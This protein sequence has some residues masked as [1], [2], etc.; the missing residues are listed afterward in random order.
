VEFKKGAFIAHP[1]MERIAISEIIVSE[2]SP[3]L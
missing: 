2:I 1:E 3:D